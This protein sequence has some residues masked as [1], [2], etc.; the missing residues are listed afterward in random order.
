MNGQHSPNESRELS[1]IV[2][3]QSSLDEHVHQLYEKTRLNEL[4][5]RLRFLTALQIEAMVGCIMP[6]LKVV[7]FGSSVNG[8]GRMGS[9]LDLVLT[10]DETQEKTI[11]LS[12]KLPLP[13]QIITKIQGGSDRAILQTAA[14][15]LE[16][17]A[18][19]LINMQ[20]ILSAKVPILKFKQAFIDLD[21]DLSAEDV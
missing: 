8:F 4:A 19:G 6:A 16:N 3:P 1:K 10:F 13:L 2:R 18:P 14:K 5:T 20:S 17:L 15:I 12:T 11:P 9:D 21:V 7:P